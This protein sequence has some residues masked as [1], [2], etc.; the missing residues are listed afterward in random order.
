MTV[1]D[2]DHRSLVLAAATND[3]TTT[4]V[5]FVQP[6]DSDR[7]VIRG[8]LDQVP[9]SV[10]HVR[11]LQHHS[12]ALSGLRE[13]AE[14]A[15]ATA[16]PISPMV[17]SIEQVPV[18]LAGMPEPSPGRNAPLRVQVARKWKAAEGVTAFEL[19]SLAGPLPTHQPG[20]HIDLHLPNGLVR[21]Y[22]LTNAAGEGTSYRIGVKLEP[23]SRG[24][25][26]CLHESVHTGDVLAISEP[27]NNFPLRR[28]AT[29]T[30]LV[31][32]GIGITPLLSMAQT[33]D[34][35]GLAYE[36]HYYA[37]SDEHLAFADVLDQLGDG[38]I[39]HLGLS[40]DE[41][42]LSLTHLLSN[43]EPRTHVYVCGPGPMLEATRRLA[44]AASWPDQAVHFEYFKNTTEIDDS[45]TFEISL[46]RSA[47]TLTVSSGET[48]LEVLRANG[49]S[50]PSSCE[51]GACGTC[52]VTVLEGAA[53]HQDVFL[54]QS[55]RLAGDRIITCVSRAQSARLVLDI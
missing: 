35:D 50:M 4:G 12:T 45:S 34:H 29:K 40:A 1:M 30:L 24:G 52:A 8:V 55:E 38:L 36:L 10:D 51:Q 16:G 28:D 25:S 39:V 18:E 17:A 41:T 15:A 9:P 6:V 19:E 32:G 22:S 20:A 5:F 46:A 53:L 43:Y 33:L 37:Q 21:Q 26:Q 14:A 54:N 42:G 13:V 23:A 3:V 7:S 48:I 44:S 49:V 31:A 27:R 2:S 11:V 47:L